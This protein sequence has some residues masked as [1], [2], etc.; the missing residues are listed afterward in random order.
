MGQPTGPNSLGTL[1]YHTRWSYK[2][3]DCNKECIRTVV[4][5]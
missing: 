1:G 3:L 2:L 4:V 5:E